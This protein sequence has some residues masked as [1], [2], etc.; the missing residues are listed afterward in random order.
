M[1]RLA[2]SL[3]GALCVVG[4]GPVE[5]RLDGAKGIPEAK[6]GTTID[7]STAGWTCGQNITSGTYT[8]V[9]TVVTGGCQFAFEQDVQVLK[10]SDY[11][12]IPELNGASNLVQRIELTILALTFTDVGTGQVLDAHTRV[13]SATLSLNGQQVADKSVLSNLP[14]TVT[15]SGDAL[16]PLKAAIDARQAASVHAKCVVVMPDTPAPPAKLKIDYDVQPAIIV[17]PGRII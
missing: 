4:C 12:G 10:A 5:V 8:V 1:S 13:T 15:L 14:K 6:G 7:L 16:T 3:V 2:W 17:G 9:T 11:A